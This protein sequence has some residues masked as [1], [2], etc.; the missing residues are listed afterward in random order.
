[1]ILADFERSLRTSLASRTSLTVTIN[2]EFTRI[3]STV[4]F[5]GTSSMKAI[6][7]RKSRL[8]HHVFTSDG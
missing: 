4:I 5:L 2:A 8:K 7:A 3:V 1:M 6:E